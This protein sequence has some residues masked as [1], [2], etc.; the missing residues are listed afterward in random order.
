MNLGKLLV[1]FETSPA[2]RLLRSQNAAFIVDFLD[3]QFKRAGRITVPLSDLHA[4]LIAYR[5]AIQE[6]DPEALRN[7]T[8]LAVLNRRTASRVSR[9][10]ASRPGRSRGPS[11]PSGRD[12]RPTC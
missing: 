12:G 7:R 3:Q 8:V 9:P 11:S 2:L 10:G 5:E 6:T 4:A 1:Y